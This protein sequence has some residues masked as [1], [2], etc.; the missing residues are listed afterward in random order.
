M[1][2]LTTVSGVEMDYLV[3]ILDFQLGRARW[4]G[5]STAR[6]TTAP[7]CSCLARPA[8]VPMPGPPFWPMGQHGHGTTKR[9]SPL[10]ARHSGM[11]AI[12]SRV[13]DDKSCWI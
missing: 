11:A 4:V 6:E 12:R 2:V 3:A 7:P 5:P 9:P 13:R 10:S 1:L 8:T